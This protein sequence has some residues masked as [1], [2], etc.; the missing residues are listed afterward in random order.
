M[1]AAPEIPPLRYAGHRSGNG[2]YR[3]VCFKP[4]I[5]PICL[6][7]ENPIAPYP[8]IGKSVLTVCCVAPRS[9]EVTPRWYH[10]SCMQKYAVEKGSNNISCIY[11]RA[12]DGEKEKS[13]FF[14]RLIDVFIYIP[15][16][17][18]SLVD[19][20]R[21][22]Y[23]NTLD[24]N[25]YCELKEDCKFIP[26][27]RQLV[28]AGDEKYIKLVEQYERDRKELYMIFE[29]KNDPTLFDGDDLYCKGSC[30]VVYH[31]ICAGPPWSDK[32]LTDLDEREYVCNDCMPSAPAVVQ[33][34]PP[35]ERVS[36]EESVVL[37]EGEPQSS[38]NS[39]LVIVESGSS[40]EIVEPEIT[41]KADEN[42]SPGREKRRKKKT[43]G[44][45]KRKS[46]R[47]S[48]PQ[49]STPNRGAEFELDTLPPSEAKPRKRGK[50]S[51]NL[52]PRKFDPK[53]STSTESCSS[54]GSSKQSKLDLY[55]V[56]LTKKT[57]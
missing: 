36:S 19:S 6:D 17:A 41:G 26:I 25:I 39:D 50:T 46:A 48:L 38:S 29:D 13:D 55:F 56:N 15:Y 21:S 43:V 40:V 1:P 3:F 23:D 52:S 28:A 51:L 42:I 53:N 22:F 49:T 4:A 2:R 18:R 57:I 35:V 34:M 27:L 9:G 5:C 12:G 11:C 8:V 7:D 45:E 24:T 54:S 31:R 33:P 14:K 32:T 37:L 16:R 30:S 20:N 10:Y 47:F 44:T